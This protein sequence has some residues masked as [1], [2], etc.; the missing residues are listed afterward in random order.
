ML[1]PLQNA[2][3]GRV[4]WQAH[5]RRQS[6]SSEIR[7]LIQHRVRGMDQDQHTSFQTAWWM[8]AAL[9]LAAALVYVGCRGSGVLAEGGMVWEGD[10]VIIVQSDSTG[11]TSL[12]VD[13]V[14][15]TLKVAEV[16]PEEVN[17]TSGYLRTEPIRVNDTLNMRLNIVATDSG[18]VELAGQ[19][20]DLRSSEPDRWMRVAWNDT[21]RRGTGLWSFMTE[22]GKALGSIEGYER[23]PQLMGAF[24]CGGRRCAEDETCEGNVCRAPDQGAIASADDDDQTPARRT[25][26]CLSE[27]EQALIASVRSYRASKNLPEVPLSG[28]LTEVAQAHVRDLAD[29]AP[30]EDRR[31]NLHSWSDEGSWSSCCYTDDHA[32]ASCMWDKPAELTDYSSSGYEI[33]YQGPSDANQIMAQWKASPGHNSVMVNRGQWANFTWRA[34]GVGVVEGFAV[35]WFGSEEDPSGVPASCTR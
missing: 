28:G 30:H 15:R 23:D 8:S 3:P 7:F 10:D 20:L 17:R 22:V 27:E 25:G 32:N 19:M 12:M 5:P 31:C 14:V 9:L 4:Y 18:R 26:T 34:M 35:I 2:E 29:E 33:A 6:C 11:S 13:R 24:E 16:S 1:Q 21:P